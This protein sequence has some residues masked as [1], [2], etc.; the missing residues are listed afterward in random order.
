[1]VKMNLNQLKK[2]YCDMPAN[3]RIDFLGWALDLEFKEGNL[4][5]KA[6]MEAIHKYRPDEE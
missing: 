6:L 3:D 1:M 2:E 4:T 5:K